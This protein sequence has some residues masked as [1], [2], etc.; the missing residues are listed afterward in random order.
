MREAPIEVDVGGVLL[1]LQ[2][3]AHDDAVAFQGIAR[4]DIHAPGWDDA[5]DHK[6]LLREVLLDTPR[7]VAEA[8]DLSSKDE[9]LF[10]E[11]HSQLT[12]E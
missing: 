6:E 8:L 2:Q 10:A 4:D 11:A 3:K 12:P 9:E 1:D 7:N 5:L